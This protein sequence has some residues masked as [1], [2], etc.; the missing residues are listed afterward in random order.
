METAT[1]PTPDKKNVLSTL[2][3]QFLFRFRLFFS[4]LNWFSMNYCP[5]TELLKVQSLRIDLINC[6][7][8]SRHD[9]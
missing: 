4:R 8:N 2:T 1:S 5:S 7:E 6:R 9:A 3:L